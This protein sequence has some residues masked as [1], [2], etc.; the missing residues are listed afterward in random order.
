M[1]QTSLNVT[2]VIV[3]N[4][5][6]SFINGVNPGSIDITLSK[7]QDLDLGAS[8]LIN[9][10]IFA[11]SNSQVTPAFFTNHTIFQNVNVTK[12]VISINLEDDLYLLLNYVYYMYNVTMTN[13]TKKDPI[14]YT[15]SASDDTGGVCFWSQ[16]VVLN[17]NKCTLINV[18]SHCIFL[19]QTYIIAQSNIFNNSRLEAISLEPRDIISDSQGVSWISMSC[20][21]PYLPNVVLPYIIGNIF[22]ENKILTRYGGVN[23]NFSKIFIF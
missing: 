21:L 3:S 9:L 12:S 20:S 4:Y 10:Q 11:N 22:I 7:F 2:N 16:R 6:N 1:E 8:S 14:N 17:I 23:Y 19:R 5:T 15:P 13:I 18:S